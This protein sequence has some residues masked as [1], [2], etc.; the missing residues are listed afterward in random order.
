MKHKWSW[1]LSLIVL[2]SLHH[3][4]AVDLRNGAI[5]T[6]S[7][8][9]YWDPNGDG[10]YE[11]TISANGSLHI[12]GDKGDIYIAGSSTISANGMTF[13]GNS[14]FAH[15]DGSAILNSFS[16]NVSI[17]QDTGSAH[18]FYNNGIT[19]FG[20]D[21]FTSDGN[22]CGNSYALADTSGGNI[23]LT[24]PKPGEVKGRNIH[25]KKVDA[26]NELILVGLIDGR[27]K[28]TLTTANF[29]LPYISL[30]ATDSLWLVTSESGGAEAPP[31]ASGNYTARWKLDEASGNVAYDLSGN[32]N[33]GILKSD[34]GRTFDFTGNTVTGALG[35]ALNFNGSD[36]FYFEVPH[37]P[38]LNNATE[39]FTVSFWFKPNVTHTTSSATTQGLFTRVVPGDGNYN[40]HFALRGNNYNGGQGTTGA[41]VVKVEG[42]PS[43][44]NYMATEPQTWNSDTWYHV[45]VNLINNASTSQ[46]YLNGVS[47]KAYTGNSGNFDLTLF[48]TNNIP[49]TFG[50]AD[51]ENFNLSGSPI[52][53]NGAID[54]VRI[55]NRNLSEAEVLELYNL[56]SP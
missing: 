41:F 28:T 44:A 21:V 23:T 12:G 13:S 24:L 20:I 37:S 3:A 31:V 26:N 47:S 17:L 15:T 33:H 29:G 51:F 39:P 5:I 38:S 27:E 9:M 40:I 54:D 42:G 34:L 1:L 55:I 48:A 53:F 10:Q 22:L 14:V 18:D 6:S 56:G 36:Q 50:R 35:T 45:A 11:V 19:E 16:N 43:S 2:L 30:T 4:Q 46:I 32:A 8:G 25:V 7:N 52:Y 49:W